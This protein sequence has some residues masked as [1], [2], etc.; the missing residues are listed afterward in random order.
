MKDKYITKYVNSI[1]KCVD[2]EKV[3]LTDLTNIINSIYEDG[4]E[5]GYNARENDEMEYDPD[6]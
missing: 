4:F 2:N 3:D 5:D 6:N 1:F